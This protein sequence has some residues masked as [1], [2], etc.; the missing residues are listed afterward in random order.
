MNIKHILKN[1]F[2]LEIN[3]IENIIKLID[4]GNTI[5]FI[6]RYRKEMTGSIDDQK[7]RELSGRL[8]YLRNL[9]SRKLE[10]KFLVSEQGKLDNKISNSIDN[11]IALSELEDI[12]RPF[13][14]KRTTK[15]SIARD[16]GISPLADIILTK[17]VDVFSVAKNY[18]D[19]DKEVLNC[20][21][22]IEYALYIIA[23]DISDNFEIRKRLRKFIYETGIIVTKA[24]DKDKDSVYTMYYDYRESVNKIVSHR[25]LAINRAEKEKIIKVSIS[26]DKKIA[27]NIIKEYFLN[28]NN[29]KNKI[30]IENACNDS[31]D[32]LIFPSIEREIRK[33]L[34]NLACDKSIKVFSNNLK[35]LIMQPPLKGYNIIGIDPGYRTGCKICVIDNTGKALDH[36]VVYFT[37]PNNKIEQSECYILNLVKKYNVNVFAIGNG[38]AS[39]EE[40]LLEKVKNLFLNL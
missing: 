28:Q 27:I 17:N 20:E 2:N 21:Q 36:G 1:E 31:F 39:R 23:E 35:Q 8:N 9:E 5:P 6:A 4:D 14:P 10:I 22:A 33:I 34:T 11:A 29:I 40:Q 25:V 15:A 18:V 7:L 16:K 13:K 24:V 32:R 12:Y 26:I 30:Y 3:H 37:P 19:V 38:T